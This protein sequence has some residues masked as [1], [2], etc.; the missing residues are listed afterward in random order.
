VRELENVIERAVILTRGPVLQVPVAEL[1]T[2]SL[3]SR[4]KEP[5]RRRNGWPSSRAL[6]EARWVIGGVEGAA[7][8]LGIKRTTL[9]SR[10]RKLGISRPQA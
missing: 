9:M 3:R 1:R 10:M 2:P 4:E 6:G 5:W 7:S 8:H